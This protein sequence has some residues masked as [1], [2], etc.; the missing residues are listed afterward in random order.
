MKKAIMIAVGV[1]VLAVVVRH[2]AGRS[3]SGAAQL[4]GAVTADDVEAAIP[5]NAGAMALDHWRLSH[6][7]D[8]A[9]RVP[10]GQGVI[11]REK[12]MQGGERL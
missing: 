5:R 8:L 2:L 6:V 9:E 3:H 12:I 7:G 1:G 11:D 10:V 4:A